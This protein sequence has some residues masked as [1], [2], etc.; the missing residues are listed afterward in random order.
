MQPYAIHAGMPGDHIGAWYKRLLECA[1]GCIP[2]K[3][4]LLSYKKQAAPSMY[5]DV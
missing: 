5:V 1:L 3:I 2:P 4:L